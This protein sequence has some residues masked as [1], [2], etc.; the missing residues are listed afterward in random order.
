[1]APGAAFQPGDMVK[2]TFQSACPRNNVRR[3]TFLTVERWVG[4]AR[5]GRP[6]AEPH[7]SAQDQGWEVVATDDDW[8]TRFAWYRYGRGTRSAAQTRWIT[9]VLPFQSFL[10]HAPF[11]NSRHHDW[12]P[13]SFAGVSW[14]IPQD[15][16]P[17][18]YRIGHHGDAKHILGSVEPFSG[19]SSEFVVGGASTQAHKLPFV[20]AL[21]RWW[22]RMVAIVSP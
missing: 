10:T 17:G 16:L 20:G 7:I 2:V 14:I 5:G 6:G 19:Y 18:R 13:L 15:T 1:M 4:P 8:A 21:V 9:R 11:F 12:S 22:R 3:S